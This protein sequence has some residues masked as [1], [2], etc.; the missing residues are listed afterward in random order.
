MYSFNVAVDKMNK[1]VPERKQR[2]ASHTERETAL[3][4]PVNQAG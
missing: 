4:A 2:D 1:I 3:L